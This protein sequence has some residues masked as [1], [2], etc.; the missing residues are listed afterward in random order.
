MQHFLSGVYIF[1]TMTD[2]DVNITTEVPDHLAVKGHC[3]ICLKY[4]L[5]RIPNFSFI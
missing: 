5:D 3:Q 2:Y 4:L 1:G